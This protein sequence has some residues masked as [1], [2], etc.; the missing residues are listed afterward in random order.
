MD[1]LE[2]LRQHDASDSPPKYESEVEYRL[3]CSGTLYRDRVLGDWT[4]SDICRLVVQEPFQTV[5][6][7]DRIDENPQ[8]LSVRFRV[9]STQAGDDRSRLT[10]YADD[11]IVDDLAAFLTAFVRRPITIIG[12][13][14]SIFLGTYP[15]P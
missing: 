7:S 2:Y 12:K 11:Q 5:V 8:E 6:C 15:S 14:R 4:K 13:T 3:L 10:Y 1:L 9:D